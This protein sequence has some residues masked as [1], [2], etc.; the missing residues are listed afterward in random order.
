MGLNVNK[1]EQQP[2]NVTV[3]TNKVNVQHFAGYAVM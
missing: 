2:L 1:Y 3:K